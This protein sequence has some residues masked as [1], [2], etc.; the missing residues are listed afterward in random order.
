MSLIILVAVANFAITP[1]ALRDPPLS[2]AQICATAWSRDARHVTKKIKARVA[3]RY[4]VSL[5]ALK[6]LVE[7]DHLIPRELGGADVDKNIWPQPLAE[8]KKYKDALENH[9]HRAV[10]KGTISLKE[11]QDAFRVPWTAS[12]EKYMGKKVP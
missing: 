2:K 7:W 4:G 10:C 1:G 5:A 6:G 9:L 3:L 12:Y 8:A 11:A